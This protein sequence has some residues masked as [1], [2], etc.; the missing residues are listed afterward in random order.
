MEEYHFNQ[1]KQED[2]SLWCFLENL[3]ALMKSA[4]QPSIPLQ[5]C[6]PTTMRNAAP[7]TKC[8]LLGGLL[9]VNPAW[10]AEWPTFRANVQRSAISTESLTLPLSRAW[11]HVPAQP[12]VPAWPEPAKTNYAVMH[13]P[14]QSTLTFDHAFHVVANADSVYY[15]SSSEDAVYC[16]DAAT[17]AVRWRFV[18]EGPVRLPPALYKDTLFAGADDGHLYALDAR[19]GELRWKYRAGEINRRLPGNGRMISLWPVRG[20]LV[21]DANTVYF[22]AGLFPEHGVYLCGVRADSGEPLFKQPLEFT[23]QGTMLASSNQL[24]LATGRFG[25]RGCDRG[26]GEPMLRYGKPNPWK[27][28]LVGGSLALLAEGILVTGPSEDGQFHWFKSGSIIPIHRAHGDSVLVRNDDVFLLHNGQ[29]SAM[30]RA[31][32]LAEQK[33]VKETPARWSLPARHATTM[34]LVGDKIVTAGSGAV[35]V[36]AANDGKELWSG[37][38]DGKVEGLAFCNNRLYASLDNG[39]TVCFQAGT[40]TAQRVTST[41]TD[42]QVYPKNPLLAQAAEIAIRTAGTTKGY[43]LVLQAGTGQLACE[44]AR[45]SEFRVICHEENP[46]KV[47]VMRDALLKAGLYG[48]RIEVHQ[49]DAG[50]LPYPK[51]FA[52]LIVSEEVLTT[53]E[54]LPLADQVLRVLRPYGGTVAMIVRPGG[55]PAHPLAAWGRALPE[56]RVV[57]TGGVT[58]GVARKGRPPGSGEW[59]HFYADPGNT[60]CSGDE[61]RPVPMD[62]QWFGRPGPRDM[63][64]RHKKGPAPLF[65][66]GRLFVPGFNHLTAL[67]AYNGV[68][69][70]E[71]QVPDSVRVAAFKDSS[72]IAATDSHLLVAAGD[73]C[74]VLDAQTGKLAK[75]IPAPGSLPQKA[76]GYL[77]TVDGMIIGSVAKTGGSL[78]AMG[79]AED[80]IVWKSDQ[81]VICSFSLFAVSHAT[82]KPAWEYPARRGAIINPTVAIGNGRIYFVESTNEQTLASPDGRI[83]L[84]DLTG[85]GSRL[86]ALDLKTG[87]PVWAKDADLG[88]MQQIIYASYAKETLLI[89]GSRHATVSTAETNGQIKPKQLTRV[90]YELRAFDARTGEPKWQV[91]ATPNYD[92]VLSDAHGEQVQ[93]PAIVGDVVYGPAFACYLATGKPYEGWKWEKSH[94]CAT[95]S[96]SR[97]CAFSRFTEAKVPYMFDL[98]NGRRTPLSTAT[99]PG[100][101][102]NT[103]PAGGLILIP[104]AS[105]G[106][107][108]EYAIQTSL[109]LAPA[110]K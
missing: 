83:L 40:A 57:S 77:A 96:T 18:A 61:I 54:N 47:K 19:T 3:A 64:D 72:C 34:I 66:N 12:P 78:R 1:E 104:E 14:L 56:W 53:G 85:A 23:S 39:Q 108:C 82:G 4:W 94:K 31:T 16:L 21:A 100:C 10:T 62:L 106:C 86:V 45:R 8:L 26:D 75:R 103:I 30:D 110:D 88:M 60:A 27:S 92:Y 97:Y 5:S 7:S 44:I 74:L 42:T 46:A 38:L 89:S 24:F 107:T 68:V 11:T 9:L 76:W 15:G 36:H 101:W 65:V 98:Q 25:F 81:P 79:K 109:A 51:H 37:N 90:R 20:G 67:D 41:P 49:G 59:S 70:W 43:C 13:G 80:I 22:T 93:H 71:Q 91:T 50:A 28:N 2:T 35:T 99:R 32:Y 17:G 105:A 69:L 52:N 48:K 87:A 55:K 73:A 102:I 58:C 84:R 6:G 95:L 63:V 29:L 33:R